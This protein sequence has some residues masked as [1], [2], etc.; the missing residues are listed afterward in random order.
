MA[1]SLN[2]MSSKIGK[3][4]RRGGVLLKLDHLSDL[5]YYSA[6]QTI[7]LEQTEH[8]HRRGNDQ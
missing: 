2:S 4:G 6:P 3:K 7:T 5:V 1:V 8:Q